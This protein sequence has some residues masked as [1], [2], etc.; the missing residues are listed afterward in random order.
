MALDYTISSKLP[1]LIMSR[2]YCILVRWNRFNSMCLLS[3][4]C[5]IFPRFVFFRHFQSLRIRQKSENSMMIYHIA[6]FL[7]NNWKCISNHMWTM[8]NIDENKFY[9]PLIE[10]DWKWIL[11]RSIK[12]MPI[13]NDVRENKIIEIVTEWGRKIWLKISV[14]ELNQSINCK[15]WI[16]E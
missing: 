5:N 12:R 6:N 9:L 4:I 7:L 3:T 14:N 2:F 16:N 13:Q 10:F 1:Q 8:A 15:C 11:H